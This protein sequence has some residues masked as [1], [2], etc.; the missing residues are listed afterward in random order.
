MSL[1]VVIL[2]DFGEVIPEVSPDCSHGLHDSLARFVSDAV[3]KVVL[4]FLL[5]QRKVDCFLGLRFATTLSPTQRYSSTQRSTTGKLVGK[6]L[7]KQPLVVNR[8]WGFGVLRRKA[9]GNFIT[10]REMRLA[11]I[12]F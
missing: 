4:F 6:A 5:Q 12:Q 7:T 8:A 2:L 11:Y 1:S 10:L 9:S 3:H